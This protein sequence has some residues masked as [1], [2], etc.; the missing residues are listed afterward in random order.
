[1]LWTIQHRSAPVVDRVFEHLSPL[2]EY[3]KEWFKKYT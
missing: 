3:I 2:G 1:M